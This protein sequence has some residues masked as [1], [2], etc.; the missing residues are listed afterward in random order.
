M[1]KIIPVIRDHV[2]YVNSLIESSIDQNSKLDVVGVYSHPST[3]LIEITVAM[4]KNKKFP[5]ALALISFTPG[6]PDNTKQSNRTY[7]TSKRE[8]IKFSVEELFSLAQAIQY[9][10]MAGQCDYNK[11]ADS[12]KF[13]GNSSQKVIKQ[14]TV[15][16]A[17]GKIYLNYKGQGK[18]S[19][20]FD[21]WAAIGFAQC[22]T[23]MANE[24][25]SVWMK[26]RALY[27]KKD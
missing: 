17:N 3:N 1:E 21:K 23:N 26:S 4:E 22:L 24:I 14:V 7:D 19:T 20:G 27:R 10:A 25:H 16:S 11:F 12:S 18:V 9:A 13:A 8:T 2:N 6:V 15:G 5:K